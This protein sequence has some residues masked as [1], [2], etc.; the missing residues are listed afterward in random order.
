MP[1]F[2][3][4]S[5]FNGKNGSH[6]KQSLYY[7]ISQDISTNK[8]TITY[9]GYVGS[10]DNYSGSGSTSTVYINGDSVGTFTSLAANS[11]GTLRGTKTVT[12]THNSDGTA[13][14]SYSMTT[15]TSWTLGDASLSGS[16]TLPTIPRYAKITS[17]SVSKRD[18]TSVTFN[19]TVDSTCDY[20]WYSKDDGA[21]WHD[22]P[23]SKVVS[24]LTANTLYNFKLK[25][26]RQDSQLSTIS[27]RYQ[28]RTHPYPSIN[29]APN[30]TIGNSLTI[31]LTN[32]LNRSCSIYLIGDD[33]VSSSATTT[34]GT[35]VSGFNN[36][37]WKNFFY[38]SIPEKQSANYKVRLVCS[39]VSR[40]TTTTGGTYSIKSTDKPVVTTGAVDTNKTLSS[41][42]TPTN[43]IQ[44]LT[45]DSTNK[46]I[47]KYI[48]DVSVSVTAE[49]TR[50]TT[51]NGST[52]STKYGD[53]LSVAGSDHTYQNVESTSFTGS[54]ND[55]RG[56]PGSSQATGLTLVNYTRL[57]VDNL[58]IYRDDQTSSTLKCRGGGSYFTNTFGTSGENNSITF[59]IR[60]KESSSSTWG[61]WTTK[62]VT[63]GTGAYTFDFTVGT[64]YDYTK[65][66]NVQ[67][68][69]TDKCM[70]TGAIE[71]TAQPGIPVQG[72]FEDFHEAFGTKTF[73]KDSNG[74]ILNSAVL[75]PN[76][77]N[78]LEED[79]NYETDV[80]YPNNFTE[81]FIEIF[82]KNSSSATSTTYLQCIIPK[83]AIENLS[84]NDYKDYRIGASYTTTT[85]FGAVVRS[86]S[87]SV[88]FK[89]AY[90][91]GSLI[92]SYSKMNVYYR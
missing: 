46:T 82:L 87:T 3:K 29:S 66:Y 41:S 10:I 85:Y 61:S 52:Y 47:I 91:N 15:D 28:Q 81:L 16:F 77:W 83:K 73:E 21:T 42:V 51:I 74:V 37:T 24:G 56:V 80:N 78:V 36:D 63:I 34:T 49:A 5:Y 48:S 9:Y 35:S 60:T 18:E 71:T 57:T 67:V 19:Y 31:G 70:T 22:L 72:L 45:N 40:D 43:T 44:D 68:R 1:T 79:V 69:A 76:E 4:E 58:E 14:A 17:F 30:F 38:D 90:W 33:N 2:L 65:T 55:R 7:D 26:R 53:N 39:A 54:V 20:A 64:S 8:S 84:S 86:S 27:D 50:G 12:V 92:N 13:T 89:D 32:P 59:E 11:S 6:F 25:L 75:P 62:T 88:Q 23:N